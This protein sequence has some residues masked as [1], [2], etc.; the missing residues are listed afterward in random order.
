MSIRLLLSHN[1][2][3]AETVAPLLSGDEFC[4][5][6]VVHLPS[7][8]VIKSVSHPHW[9]CEVHAEG[10]PAI[11]GEALINAVVAYR[12]EQ[13]QQALSYSVLALGGLKNTPAPSS[14]PNALQKGDWGVDV[15]ET[16][17]AETFLQTLGW[18]TLIAGRPEQEIF[19]V[20]LG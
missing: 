11:I 16:P 7:D 18:E 8:W 19:K 15:I 3:I 12:T 9:R 6:L 17:D 14:A 13:L 5:L 2:N 20:V 10:S 4:N 1:Y